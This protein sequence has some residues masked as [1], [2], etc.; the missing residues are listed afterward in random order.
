MLA[1]KS[2]FSLHSAPR[3]RL[4]WQLHIQILSTPS[5]PAIHIQLLQF[6][7]MMKNE[8]TVREAFAANHIMQEEIE[9]VFELL[10]R[11]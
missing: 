7:Y 9:I 6:S 8:E 1:A 3:N 4:Q 11:H 5:S 10:L 2:V